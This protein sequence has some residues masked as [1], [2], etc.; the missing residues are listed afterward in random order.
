[1]YK[2]ADMPIVPMALNSGLFWGRNHF[3]KKPGKVVFEFLPAIE[4]GLS[5]KKVIA[6]IEERL[7][8][9]TYALMQEAKSNHKYLT[10]PLPP[11]L[12]AEKP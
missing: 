6:A 5:D 7:E 2:H 12:I 3:F 9:K 10:A 4:S 11:K 1:M 8:E